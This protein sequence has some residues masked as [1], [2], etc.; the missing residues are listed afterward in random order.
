MWSRLSFFQING[1]FGSPNLLV[2]NFC[3]RYFMPFLLH[4]SFIFISLAKFSIISLIPTTIFPTSVVSSMNYYTLSAASRNKSRFFI[5]LFFWGG[6][7]GEGASHSFQFTSWGVLNLTICVRL[8][9]Q[10]VEDIVFTLDHEG[11]ELELPLDP[12]LGF[13][14]RISQKIILSKTQLWFG[15][16]C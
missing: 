2:T 10:G 1:V 16:F 14:W 8:W 15:Y 12:L 9:H 4:F 13:I 6:E 3:I 11:F 7:L 5:W